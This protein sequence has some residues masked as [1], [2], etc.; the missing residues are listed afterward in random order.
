MT[1]N[2]LQS[3]PPRRAI[4]WQQVGQP[5]LVP[6]PEQRQPPVRVQGTGQPC[7]PVRLL[8]AST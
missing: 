6:V 8:P 4:C 5:P 3:S 1:T 2:P 7:L